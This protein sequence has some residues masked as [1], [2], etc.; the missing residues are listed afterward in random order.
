MVVQKNQ[1]FTKHWWCD[2]YWYWSGFEA[3]ST[4]STSDIAAAAVAA[5]RTFFYWIIFGPCVSKLLPPHSNVKALFY[6]DMH[7]PFTCI[8]KRWKYFIKFILK[9]QGFVFLHL[10]SSSSWYFCY[11]FVRLVLF[12]R[13]NPPCKIR[14]IYTLT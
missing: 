8:C 6:V 9:S 1:H 5:T 12:G 3:T 7:W 11:L 2:C 10:S 4:A 14:Y 13:T